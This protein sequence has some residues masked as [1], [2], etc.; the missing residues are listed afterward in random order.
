MDQ[1]VQSLM[2]MMMMM[3]MMHLNLMP[4]QVLK[5]IRRNTLDVPSDRIRLTLDNAKYTKLARGQCAVNVQCAN[6][7]EKGVR[8][9]VSCKDYCR[10]NA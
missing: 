3:M 10:L 6:F 2:F 5:R 7:T 8:L 9:G 4:T 1:R